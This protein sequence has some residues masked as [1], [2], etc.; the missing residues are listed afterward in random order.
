M[1]LLLMLLAT[2]LCAQNFGVFRSTDLGATWTNASSGLSASIRVN[3]FAVSANSYIAATDEGIYLSRNEASSWKLAHPGVRALSLTALGNHVFAGTDQMG[4]LRSNDSGLHWQSIARSQFRY[5][6]SL[7]AHEGVVYA[8]TDAQG[9]Y[10][11][12]DQGQSWQPLSSGL[13]QHSQIFSMVVHQGALH[14]ALYRNGLYRLE[15]QLKIWTKVGNVVPLA[16]AS[17]GNALFAGLNPGGIRQTNEA[18]RVWSVAKLPFAPNLGQSP[19]WELAASNRLVL[20]GV[21]SYIYRSLDQGRTWTPIENGIPAGATGIAFLTNPKLA[22]AGV[23]LL[24]R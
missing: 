23:N 18:N 20:A 15:P 11:S 24:L 6:R 22:L 10:A 7:A 13:P 17:S 12:S 16:L 14:A 4:L 9:V 1:L 19:V 3:A 2:S 21:S 5:V 8:G